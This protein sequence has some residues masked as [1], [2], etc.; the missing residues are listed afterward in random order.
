MSRAT[1]SVAFLLIS[2]GTAAALTACGAGRPAQGGAEP[3]FSGAAAA[4]TSASAP[5][6]SN[7]SA[8]GAAGSGAPGDSNTAGSN[9]ADN[10]RNG[11]QQDPQ[12]IKAARCAPS[13]LSGRLVAGSPGAGQR[14]A[15]LIVTNSSH[16]NCTLYGYSGLQLTDSDGKPL[17][18]QL[19]R[20][21]NP[22]PR[23]VV[24]ATGKSASA[25]LHWGVVPGSGEPD[26]GPCEPTPTSIAV[27]PPDE[28]S[29]F[30]APW[31][32]GPVCQGGRIEVSAYH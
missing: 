26:T 25:D 6:A 3:S 2:V 16:A 18:T 22:A 4:T 24:L 20:A 5:G 21:A 12:A 15:T 14:Y 27:I 1:R 7:G 28:Y 8:H 9:Q 32:F 13:M 31:N 30:S 19:V 29:P 10:Q 11:D 23:L 17:P